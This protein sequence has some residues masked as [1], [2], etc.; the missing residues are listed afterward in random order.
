MVTESLQNLRGPTR[1]AVR[2][3]RSLDR[4]NNPSYDLDHDA[5]LALMYQT[6]LRE[7]VSTSQLHRWLDGDTL[8]RVWPTL[9]LP[10]ALRATW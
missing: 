9:W 6:V 2:L 4:S 1:R 5:D 3:D 10:S 8:R 7:A